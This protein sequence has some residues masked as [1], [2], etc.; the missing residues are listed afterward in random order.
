M[1]C[2]VFALF[3][4]F[5]LFFFFWGEGVVIPLRLRLSKKINFISFYL[6]GKSSILL[7]TP[8]PANDNPQIIE[9]LKS[10]EI[11]GRRHGWSIHNIIID[12]CVCILNLA[13]SAVKLNISVAK[14]AKF[15]WKRSIFIFQNTENKTRI[16]W[17]HSF[18]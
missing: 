7:K 18:E 16:I 13:L 17:M 11:H 12:R 3:V 9:T 14:V 4:L 15:K 10:F 1:F 2:F 5:F 6:L 8:L